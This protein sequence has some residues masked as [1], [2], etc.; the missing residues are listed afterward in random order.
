[1]QNIA[2][3]KCYTCGKKGHYVGDCPEPPKVPFFT[4]SPKLYVCY[5]ALVANSFPNW[6]VDMGASKHIVCDQ[7]GF[8]DFHHYPVGSH[9]IVLGNESKEDVL[10]FGTYKLRLHGASLE[11]SQCTWG[12]CLYFVFSFFDKIK[13]LFPILVLLV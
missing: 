13:V 1:M 10:D 12:V 6:I 11:C 2:G 8:M 9:T 3:V 7:A 5:Y 4:S